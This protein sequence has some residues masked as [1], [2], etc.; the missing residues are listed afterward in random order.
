[1]NSELIEITIAEKEAEFAAVKAIL[2]EY[3]KL[4]NF[5]AALGDFEK[6]LDNLPGEFASPAGVLLLA[7]FQ[8]EPAGIVF[9]RK[10]D[11]GICEMKRLF[12]LHKF[13][14]NKIGRQLTAQVIEA[15]RK[16]GYKK[17]RLD[18]HPWMKAAQDMY[19][20][21]GFKEIPAYRFNPTKGIRFFE[22]EL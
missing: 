6:E 5:D 4:R 9:L 2:L 17:M 18:T 3:G 22:L 14:G 7:Y 12:V 11:V 16:I 10:I 1:M 13:Q 15:A 21:F 20:Q 19:E 8:K